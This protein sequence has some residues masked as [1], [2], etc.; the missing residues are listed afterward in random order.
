M[1]HIIVDIKKLKLLTKVG[2][3]SILFTI[4]CTGIAA[5]ISIPTHFVD[6]SAVGLNNQS[7]YTSIEL[8]ITPE[9]LQGINDEYKAK[10][11][12]K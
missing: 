5:A 11:G 12:K 1:L 6:S 8:D 7:G 9:V 10:K 3:I 2:A 4:L